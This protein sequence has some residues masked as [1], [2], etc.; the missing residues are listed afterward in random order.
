M[1]SSK[2][3]N[4]FALA[5]IAL[6]AIACPMAKPGDIEQRVPRRHT[7]EADGLIVPFSEMIA[8]MRAATCEMD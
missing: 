6:V 2:A 4:P 7:D 1:L 3:A 5:A 8:L